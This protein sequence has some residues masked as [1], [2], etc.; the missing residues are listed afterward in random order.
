LASKDCLNVVSLILRMLSHCFILQFILLP[1]SHAQNQDIEK[2][3]NVVTKQCQSVGITQPTS[4]KHTQSVILPIG[5]SSNKTQSKKLVFH[6]YNAKTFHMA[7]KVYLMNGQVKQAYQI[8]KAA[9]RLAPDNLI[10]RQQLAKAAA[11]SG[12]LDIALEQYLYLFNHSSQKS[13]YAD[14]IIPLGTQVSDYHTV[15]NVLTFLLKL[16]PLDPSL[17]L[18]YVAALQAQGKAQQALDYLNQHPAFFANPAFM[19]Q[20]VEIAIGLNDTNLLEK[21]LQRWEQLEPQNTKPYWMEANLQMNRGKLQAS[22]TILKQMRQLKPQQGLAFW[23]Q[24]AALAQLLGDM[25]GCVVAYQNI[26]LLK[27]DEASTSLNLINVWSLEGHIKA[28]YH[29]AR[30]A[31]NTLHQTEAFPIVMQQGALLK[32]WHEIERVFRSAPPTVQQD[33]LQQTGHQV[34]IAQMYTHLD[35][36]AEAF[37]WWQFVLHNHPNDKDVQNNFLWFLID[38]RQYKALSYYIAKN[39]V[40]WQRQPQTWRTTV[41]ALSLLGKNQTAYQVSLQ[42]FPWISRHI[43]GLLDLADLAQALNHTDQ[44]TQLRMNALSLQ[45]KRTR[46][47][48]SAIDDI[49]QLNRLA[50]YFTDNTTRY[51]IMLSLQHAL[52]T[53][54]DVSEAILGYLWDM[55][56]ISAFRQLKQ[57]IEQ[58]GETIP[59]SLA[60]SYAISQQDRA[61]IESIVERVPTLSADQ[62]VEAA[63]A[64]RRT[65]QAQQAAY[66]ALEQR[67]GDT[68][69]YEQFKEIML[70]QANRFSIDTYYDV[71]SPV[72]GFKNLTSFQ[73]FI[74]P[75]TGVSVWNQLWRVHSQ[76]NQVMTNLPNTLRLTGVKIKR[77]VE[78]GYWE[79]ALIEHDGLCQNV[80]VNYNSHYAVLP[81]LNAELELGY[82]MPATE[83]APLVIGGMRNTANASLIYDVNTKLSLHSQADYW[84]YLGQNHQH[85]GDGSGMLFYGQYQWTWRDPD[86]NA[87]VYWTTRHFSD[88]NILLHSPLQQI[89]PANTT[90]TST[91]YMPIGYQEVGAMFGFGQKYRLQYNQDWRLFAEVG[92]TSSN[93][94]GVGKI[95]SGG[96]TGKLLGRDKLLLYIN[97]STNTQQGMQTLYS[98]GARYDVYF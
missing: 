59:A 11:W 8:A 86:W 40:R 67:P 15:A 47:K 84:Q 69:T 27:P 76:N 3:P 78:R 25:S 61:Q 9:V 71:F 41:A 81:R 87:S 6:Q 70:E 1:L 34:L 2:K 91:Y 37:R 79:G 80:A 42:H 94:F 72:A 56:S 62:Q 64:L 33:F 65:H 26:L 73:T 19:P 30:R 74:E 12:H 85:L 28:A 55:H 53:R 14:K 36:V 24:Y 60:L 16:R 90:P 22:Y 51:A 44:A 93:A 43:S 13:E 20:Y 18:K 48:S 54:S 97:Y 68:N 39:G 7:Y 89:V 23:F 10:W 29:L 95:A 75:Q 98:A 57:H 50:T 31:Y 49:L 35:R 58:Q 66:H 45:S 88:R 46:V 21:T 63:V 96:L 38:Q 32:Q 82:Q 17:Q 4:L 52:L 92:M 77:L 83:T 5:V